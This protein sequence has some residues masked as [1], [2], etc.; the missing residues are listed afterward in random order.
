M[1]KR[2]KIPNWSKSELAAIKSMQSGLKDIYKIKDSNISAMASVIEKMEPMISSMS[3]FKENIKPIVERQ[4][5]INNLIKA[6]SIPI[7][8][9]QQFATQQ[10]VLKTIIAAS[11]SAY[12]KQFEII[13]ENQILFASVAASLSSMY[14]ELDIEEKRRFEEMD[15]S[16]SEEEVKE[17]DAMVGTD[18]TARKVP[19]SY[20]I[21]MF[22][23]ILQLVSFGKFEESRE[24][25]GKNIVEYNPSPAFVDATKSICYAL[26][27]D[28]LKIGYAKLKCYIKTC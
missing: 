11:I 12:S 3:A 10:D 16:Q 7:S 9:L 15:K 23:I 2:V 18:K 26:I 17:L 27:Y 28:I 14:K 20:L 4:M 6:S 5:E 13:K 8:A 25:E 1:V 22:F 19:I 24:V 21:I